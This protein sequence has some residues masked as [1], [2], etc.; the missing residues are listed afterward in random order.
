M[1]WKILQLESRASE[2]R[3]K[4]LAV[5]QC[6]SSLYTVQ[7]EE[8]QLVSS[9][10]QCGIAHT[11]VGVGRSI[12]CQLLTTYTIYHTVKETWSQFRKC[13]CKLV[14]VALSV[15]RRA[16]INCV[17]ITKSNTLLVQAYK[18]PQKEQ[19]IMKSISH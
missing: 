17:R 1:N 15:T 6:T 10:I 13:T 2:L 7:C 12:H 16:L 9:A 14:I 5:C 19:E 8:L 18:A 4:S 3:L 11:A